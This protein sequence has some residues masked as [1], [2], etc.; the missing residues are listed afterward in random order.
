MLNNLSYFIL[1]SH[2]FVSDLNFVRQYLD[3]IWLFCKKILREE[4]EYEYIG[5]YDVLNR[6][7]SKN[8]NAFDCILREEIGKKNI[9]PKAIQFFLWSIE[10]CRKTSLRNLKLLRKLIDEVLLNYELHDRIK[11]RKKGQMHTQVLTF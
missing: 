10:V 2:F 9:S 8:K 4:F 11:E 1:H 6:N 7:V 5:I 3:G